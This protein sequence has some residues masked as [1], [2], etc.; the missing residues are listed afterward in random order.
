MPYGLQ[1]RR[2]AKS[3]PKSVEQ[4]AHKDYVD[5]VRLLDNSSNDKPPHL[6][7]DSANDP[8]FEKEGNTVD[9]MKWIKKEQESSEHQKEA[10]KM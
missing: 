9:V 1:I 4:L 2:T 10:A 8:G 7:Y 6:V 5:R 3:A